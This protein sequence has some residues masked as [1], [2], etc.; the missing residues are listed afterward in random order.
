MMAAG[1]GKYDDL[2]TY[3]REQA[4][5]LEGGEPGAAIVI[6]VGGNRGSGFA[7]QATVPEH[8]P[9]LDIPAMLETIAKQIRIDRNRGGLN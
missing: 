5:I 1:P 3:V 4:G 9:E 6:V 2:C 8:S 7:V